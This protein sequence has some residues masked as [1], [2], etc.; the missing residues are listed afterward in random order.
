MNT[1]FKTAVKWLNNSYILFNDIF[2]LD[3][4]Y[5]PSAYD[6]EVFQYYISDATEDEAEWLHDHFK[7]HFGYS[8]LLDKYILEVT[9]YGCSWDMVPCWTDIANAAIS[10]L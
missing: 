8:P 4:N 7:L 5:E 2:K 6:E 9:H 3:S 10:N 1:S